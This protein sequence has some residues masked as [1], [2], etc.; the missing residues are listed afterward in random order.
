MFASFDSTSKKIISLAVSVS[1]ILLA[2]SLF[3]FSIQQANA[4]APDKILNKSGSLVN[5]PCQ[6]FHVQ[7]DRA[8]WLD[9]N[10]VL[11]Y[12]LLKNAK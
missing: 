4:K 9:A 6:W 3:I 10:G 7:D 2:A 5:N 8:Y 11:N 1:M 12:Q